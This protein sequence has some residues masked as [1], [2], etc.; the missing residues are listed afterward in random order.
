MCAISG[1]IPASPYL[2]AGQALAP[3]RDQGVLI[4]GSGNS[5]HNMQVMMHAWHTGSAVVHGLDFDAWLSEAVS[6]PDPTERNRRL[7]DWLRAPGARE[8]A[9]RE[10]HLIPLLVAAGAAGGDSGA[11]IFEDRVMGAVQSAFRFG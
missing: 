6:H 11:K 2:A 4:I 3:L 7:L 5:Y 1:L 8:A 9:P 10:E